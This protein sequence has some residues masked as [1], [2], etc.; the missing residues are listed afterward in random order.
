VPHE[1]EGVSSLR[2][3]GVA[4]LLKLLEK[5]VKKLSLEDVEITAEELAFELTPIVLQAVSPETQRTLAQVR[6]RIAE[7]AGLLGITAVP[8]T[9]APA[10][11]PVEKPLE[12][13]K[14]AF[15]PPIFSYSGEIAEVQIGATSKEGGT[16]KRV[17]KIGGEKSPSFYRFENLTPNRPVVALDVFDSLPPLPRTIKDWYTGVLDDHVAWI[18]KCIEEYGSDLVTVHLV[19]TDPYVKNTPAKEAAKFIDKILD[20]V[21]EPFM[22]G[23]SGDPKKDLEVF[24][25]VAKVAKGER[26]VLASVTLDMDLE[27]S[28]KI[29]SENNLNVIALAFL[30]INQVK[31]LNSKLIDYGV[32]KN[33]LITD[34]STGGLGYGLEYSFSMMERMR[35]AG[36]MGDPVMQV[37]ISCAATNGWAAREAW[38]K[39]EEWGPREYRGPLWEAVTGLLGM[40]AGADLFMMMHPLAAQILK[41][42]SEILSKHPLK[43]DWREIPYENWVTMKI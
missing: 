39:V 13:E 4:E 25:E 31:E 28:A 15:E 5:K 8:P 36:L 23:G 27:K 42:T 11:P 38:M 29:I 10:A 21:D 18:K 20:V 41:K 17:I 14:V 30:D 19:S 16:R 40:F 26:L 35:L 34:P 43:D 1:H 7:L 6:E 32:S 12:L 33:Q 3:I 24:S 9:P 2:G 22:V 37:P